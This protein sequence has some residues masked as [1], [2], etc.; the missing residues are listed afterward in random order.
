MS[1]NTNKLKAKG[2]LYYIL[3]I[4]WKEFIFKTF[5]WDIYVEIQ[6]DTHLTPVFLNDLPYE[7]TF[8][9]VSGFVDLFFSQVN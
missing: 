8:Q 2:M 5:L 1:G 7:Y 9:I 4:W 3:R 6:T